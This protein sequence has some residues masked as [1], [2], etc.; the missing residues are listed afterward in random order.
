LN[1]AAV[2]WDAVNIGA[3]RDINIFDGQSIKNL[4]GGRPTYSV[5]QVVVANEEEDRDAI[6][7]QEVNSFGKFP[8]LG[9]GRLTALVGIAAEEDKVYLIFQGIV[10]NLVKN[11]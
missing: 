10:Y 7:G 5:R 2:S 8:L 9:L 3:V 6:S 1:R 11:R 4:G